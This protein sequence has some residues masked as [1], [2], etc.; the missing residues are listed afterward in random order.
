VGFLA[1]Q[2][3]GRGG[4][5][6]AL[7]VTRRRCARVPACTA[8]RP[9]VGWR[10]GKHAA[11]AGRGSRAVRASGRGPRRGDRRTEAGLDVRYD[12]GSGVVRGTARDVAR[13]GANAWRRHPVAIDLARFNCVLL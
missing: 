2:G 12:G 3:D 9:L 4:T 1:H 11:S 13:V 5:G 8:A 6:V 7:A 10:G